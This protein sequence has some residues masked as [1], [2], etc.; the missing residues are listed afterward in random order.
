VDIAIRDN[1]MFADNYTDLIT[2]NLSDVTNP[3]LAGRI[4][5]AFQHFGE[6]P[7]G[8]LVD[9][10]YEQVTEMVDCNDNSWGR[11]GAENGG[12]LI[13]QEV[14]FDG[15]FKN[16][17]GDGTGGSLARFSL[18]DQYLYVI[19]EF[20]LHSYNIANLSNP[21]KTG[22][23]NIG[24]GIETLYAFGDK[25]FIG[26]QAGMFIYDA[27]NPASPQYLSGY[28]HWTACDP[29]FVKDNYAYVTLRDG[30]LCNGSE[31]NQMD[32]VDIT[33]IL[34]PILVKSFPMDNP[35]GLSI[36]DNNLFLCEGESGLKVFDIENPLTL[37]QR[38]L[39]KLTELSA[40]DV[41][42]LPQF[43][44]VLLVIGTDGFYQVNF[45]NPEEL[46]VL[47]FVKTK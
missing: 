28:A 23:T 42:V 24:W 31:L 7:D 44:N 33:D 32:L 8:I 10:L 46:E 30:A 15:D 17:G 40:V 41:I 34:N 35:H 25:L 21:V 43:D 12:V 18:Y 19:T 6:T 27:S 4:E 1:I 3:T 9:Y 29:V 14:N 2:I 38:L 39:S 20:S 13:D 47:S 36:K 26:S 45:A 22:E 37:D 16:N 11:G 5:N